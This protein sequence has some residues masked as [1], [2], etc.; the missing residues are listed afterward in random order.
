LVAASGLL[1]FYYDGFIWKVRERSTREHLGLTGGAAAAAA[2]AKDLFPS[3]LLHGLKWVA[4]FIIPLGALWV[5]QTHSKTPEPERFGWIAADLPDSVRAHHRYGLALE[6]LH[7]APEAADQYRV[8]LQ[9][10]PDAGEVHYS[11]GNLLLSESKFDE[12]ATH[13]EQA[14]SKDP[15]NGDIH[16]DYGYLLE[17]FG[18]KDKAMSE[19]TIAVRLSPK[20]ARAHYNLAMF[21]AG[22]NKLDEAGEEFEKSLNY[23]PKSS[24]A[25]YH[26]GHVL[27]LKGDLEGARAHY[28]QTARLDPAAPVHN[29][30]GVV[31]M[32]LGQVSDAIAQFEEALRQHPD[33]AG[34]AENLRFVRAGGRANTSPRP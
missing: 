5:G 7:R 25:H 33:D 29:S 9:L 28:E 17:K 21:L 16:S 26:Y 6:A 24:E 19:L 31:Y 15:R 30:L 1:H 27:F 2:T 23:N 34:A 4:V 18:Q 10:N 20:S 12:A 13:F 14:L 8:A 22:D 3:W 32:R 11:L